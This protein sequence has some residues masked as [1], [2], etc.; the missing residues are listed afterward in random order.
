MQELLNLETKIKQGEDAIKE[1]ESIDASI[2]DE[3]NEYVEEARN[4][5]VTHNINKSICTNDILTTQTLFITAKKYYD[6]YMVSISNDEY[7]E[8]LTQFDLFFD[9][10]TLTISNTRLRFN[11]EEF[12]EKRNKIIERIGNSDIVTD[13]TIFHT[14]D[15]SAHNENSNTNGSAPNINITGAVNMVI[16]TPVSNNLQINSGIPIASAYIDNNIT[17]SNNLLTNS[18]NNN[19]NNDS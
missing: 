10:K 9:V 8:A 6:G 16:S 17:D 12:E 18:T 4:F 15:I 2:L 5:L 3:W 7:L 1:L 13:L 19:Q 11:K 14:L